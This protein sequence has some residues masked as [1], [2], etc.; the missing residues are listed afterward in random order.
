MVDNWSC[1]VALS[2][3]TGGVSTT[4]T[5]ADVTRPLRNWALRK[6]GP[7][8]LKLLEC[9]YCLSHWVAL[10]LALVA[11]PSLVPGPDWF[12]ALITW[13]AIVVLATPVELMIITV[14]RRI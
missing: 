1:V 6:L 10:P 14:W 7:L 5:R 2:L 12:Q 13:Q 8:A 9:P 11:G 4:I 3:F